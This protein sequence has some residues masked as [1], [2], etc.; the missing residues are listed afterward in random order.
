MSRCISVLASTAARP[1][2]EVMARVLEVSRGGEQGVPNH[3]PGEHVACALHM[4][5]HVRG[6]HRCAGCRTCVG[7][8]RPHRPAPLQPRPVSR[9]VCER[10]GL[11]S[12]AGGHAQEKAHRRAVR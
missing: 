9:G 7:G 12:R 10:L 2:R 5:P 3:P 4:G 1:A 6:A 11:G 8:A